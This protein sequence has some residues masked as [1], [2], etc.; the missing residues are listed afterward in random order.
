MRPDHYRSASLKQ[1]L[2][3]P[4]QGLVTKTWLANKLA[5]EANMLEHML[6]VNALRDSSCESMDIS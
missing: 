6:P 5:E 1:V 2:C 3:K 4:G